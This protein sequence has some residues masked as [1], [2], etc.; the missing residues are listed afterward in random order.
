MTNQYGPK[1]RQRF[2]K[3]YADQGSAAEDTD[4]VPACDARFAQQC[5]ERGSQSPTIGSSARMPALLAF[6]GK[7]TV[8]SAYTARRHATVC[9]QRA[10]LRL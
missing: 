4:D 1:L 2:L 6:D 7:T 8:S 9:S 5:P 10:T 3:R